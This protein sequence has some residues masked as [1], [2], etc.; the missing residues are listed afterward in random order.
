MSRII[1]EG[2]DKSGK[3]T[4]IEKMKNQFEYGLAIKNMIKPKDASEEE[5]ETNPRA[6]SA[7]LRV[8]EKL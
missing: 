4:I 7:K 3:S 6:R 2:V 1:I 5:T 8:L